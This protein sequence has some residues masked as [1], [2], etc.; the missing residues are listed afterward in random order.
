MLLLQATVLGCGSS[1]PAAESATNT[2]APVPLSEGDLL[3]VVATTNIIGDVVK[4]VGHDQIALTVLMDVGVDP[5]SYVPTPA[6][7]AALHDA[8]LIFAN[9][10]GLEAD[11]EEMFASAGGDA[12][13]IHLSDDLGTLLAAEGTEHE[14]DSSEEGGA[15]PHVWFDVQNV[16]KWVKAIEQALSALDPDNA[17]T[18][19]EHAR[20]YTSE[21][22]LLDD[23]IEDQVDSLPVDGRELITNHPAFG[24]FAERYGLTQIG[25][26][27][28]VSP[29]AEPSAQD[30]AALEDAIRDY[31]VPAVFTESTVN[32]KLAKQIADDTGVALVQLYSGS[33]G[34]PGSGAE[35][36]LQFMR[37]N[38]ST[39]VKALE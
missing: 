4:N 11:L 14:G 29:S 22:Q 20:A 32:A 34:E 9:G 37:Y 8:H 31:D 39:I 21:L 1:P 18:F 15:D 26:V 3:R 28:P 30:I 2:L 12:I 23:W 5:H 16:I 35:T 25:A 27:Y 6:H 33:L 7:A 24:Y 36:Y 10:L 17:P 19:T 13:R 38:A